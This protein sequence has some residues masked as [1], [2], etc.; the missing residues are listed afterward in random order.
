MLTGNKKNNCLTIWS[1]QIFPEML[2]VVLKILPLHSSSSS[3]QLVPLKPEMQLVHCGIPVA[4]WQNTFGLQGPKHFIP[5]GQFTLVSR[6]GSSMV[7]F[8]PEDNKIWF[9][10]SHQV[11][12][13]TINN[14]STQYKSVSVKHARYIDFIGNAPQKKQAVRP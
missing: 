11:L 7:Q 3:S 12:V 4:P 6:Q 5:R 13:L 10:Y 2:I 8:I 14:T 1:T 9:Q